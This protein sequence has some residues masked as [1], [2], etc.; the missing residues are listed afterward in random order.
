MK[1]KALLR[2]NEEVVTRTTFTESETSKH[3]YRK[4][5]P[6]YFPDELET[7]NCESISETS[8]TSTFDVNNKKC[9]IQFQECSQNESD[10]RIFSPSLFSE[11]QHEHRP[12]KKSPI[13]V[14]TE[15]YLQD[16]TNFSL[17]GRSENVEILNYPENSKKKSELCVSMKCSFDSSNMKW[18]V[19]KESFMSTSLDQITAALRARKCTDDRFLV[20]RFHVDISPDKNEIAEEELR[21]QISK[22]MF[23][24]VNYFNLPTS[25]RRILNFEIM[26]FI[27]ESVNRNQKVLTKFRDNLIGIDYFRSSFPCS[28]IL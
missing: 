16:G 26:K 13:Q 5:V 24:K 11:Q 12:V 27:F 8:C 18:N 19:A 1:S 20:N 15:F 17:V 7:R 9:S 10:N 22:D 28:F 3:E 21:K 4:I 23:Q 2:F 25:V 14:S 6:E